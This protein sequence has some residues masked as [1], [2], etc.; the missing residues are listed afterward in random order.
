MDTIVCSS[1]R[2]LS[3]QYPPD[4]PE[5]AQALWVSD[6]VNEC[7]RRGR[8][9]F[10]KPYPGVF[11]EQ[12]QISRFLQG[13][14]DG[15]YRVK[16]NKGDGVEYLTQS[17][18]WVLR[19]YMFRAM[20][21]KITRRCATCGAVLKMSQYACH[22]VDGTVR[23]NTMVKKEAKAT[24]KG[25]KFDPMESDNVDV[26]VAELSTNIIES[27]DGAADAHTRHNGDVF[28]HSQFVSI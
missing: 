6:I 25:K 23:D 21:K 15:L 24:V 14:M 18:I 1:R 11:D 16:W 22:N 9:R 7:L 28:G 4:L 8:M 5:H 10:P 19:T 12:D 13:V 2:S 27:Y 26:F 3:I 20:A 17:G